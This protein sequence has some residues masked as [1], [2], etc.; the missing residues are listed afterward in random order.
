LF[1]LDAVP[2][3]NIHELRLA[4]WERIRQRGLWRFA[5]V[6]GVLFY[7]GFLWLGFSVIAWSRYSF[8]AWIHFVVI[9]APLAMLAGLGYGVTMYFVTIRIY[10]RYKG[11]L[12]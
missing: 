11:G 4:R 9:M 1:S 12:S 10:R 3:S 8:T 5:L 7:G 6:R 2:V